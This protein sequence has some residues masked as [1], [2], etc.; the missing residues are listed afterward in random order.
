MAKLGFV[1]EMMA[2]SMKRNL[3]N[4]VKDE[5]SMSFL[6]KQ[7][8]MEVG[9]GEFTNLKI[10]ISHE[11]NSNRHNSKISMGFYIYRYKQNINMGSPLIKKPFYKIK[12]FYL[13]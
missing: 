2:S 10:K 7:V 11:S 8:M 6:L 1:L 12:K 13:I 3:T 4:F 5:P 9:K